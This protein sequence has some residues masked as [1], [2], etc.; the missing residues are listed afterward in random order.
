LQFFSSEKRLQPIVM[1]RETIKT[2]AAACVNTRTNKP[3]LEV[4][5]S[6]T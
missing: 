4:L 1:R 6:N 3:R 2:H 5:P